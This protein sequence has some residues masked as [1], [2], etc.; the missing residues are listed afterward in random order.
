MRYALIALT[1]LAAGGSGTVRARTLDAVR[2]SGVI[3]MCAHPNSLP[4]ASSTANPPGFQVELGRALAES[5]R[6]VADDGLDPDHLSGA[7]HR[8]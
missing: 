6:R 8:L 1:I 3:R 5:A 2:E 7:A 4:F